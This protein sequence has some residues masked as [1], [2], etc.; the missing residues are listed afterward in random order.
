VLLS[1]KGG[2]DA[3][4]GAIAFMNRFSKHHELVHKWQLEKA[5]DTWGIPDRPLACSDS[6]EPLFT[7]RFE[8]RFKWAL[9]APATNWYRQHPELKRKGPT[10][11]QA[12]WPGMSEATGDI[13]APEAFAR[14]SAY[15]KAFHSNVVSEFRN[16]DKDCS[17]ALS[18]DELRKAFSK[19]GM[20]LPASTWEKVIR[21]IDDNS[22]L[23]LEYEELLAAMKRFERGGW[24]AVERKYLAKRTPEE[25][26]KAAVLFNIAMEKIR[27]AAYG[28]EWRPEADRMAHLKQVFLEMDKNNDRMLEKEELAAYLGYRKPQ[29]NEDGESQATEK[30]EAVAQSD[31]GDSKPGIHA[32][33]AEEELDALFEYFDRDGGGCDFAEFAYTFFNRRQMEIRVRENPTLRTQTT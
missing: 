8:Y 26:A 16:F 13:G 24:A 20:P 14:L 3:R 28:D 19:L 18:V 21:T 22:T 6:V 30:D 11:A 5:L 31:A 7:L 9:Q 1:L 33:L 29:V 10:A 12:F 2:A 32:G 15:I 17:G 25:E 27:K 4:D 23:E